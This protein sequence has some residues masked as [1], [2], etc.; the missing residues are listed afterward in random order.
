[1]RGFKSPAPAVRRLA[2]FGG[3]LVVAL[4]LADVT[5]SA[6]EDRASALVEQLASPNKAPGLGPKDGGVGDIR[7]GFDW[8]AQQRVHDAWDELVRMEEKAF[9]ALI[10]H[11]DDRRY[12]TSLSFSYLVD[13]NVGE[14]CRMILASQLELFYRQLGHDHAA[15]LFEVEPSYIAAHFNDRKMA[16]EW[17]M[18]HKGKKLQEIQVAVLEWLI[19]QGQ[20]REFSSIVHEANALGPL[21]YLID[22]L[23]KTGKPLPANPVFA[24]ARMR[25]RAR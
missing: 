12:C 24:K 5:R 7:K 14:I 17:T 25:I 20:K 18:Q 2:A 3:T 13:Q 19:T 9:P 21:R 10:R 22:H 4:F 6:E 1:M 11:L 16:E 15:G 23:Q 8:K